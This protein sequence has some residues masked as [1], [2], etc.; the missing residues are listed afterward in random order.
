MQYTIGVTVHALCACTKD[1]R[2][3]AVLTWDV[4]N[5]S[6]CSA[7]CF[8]LCTNLSSQQHVH[9]GND[10]SCMQQEC[11]HIQYFVSRL[12]YL[13]DGGRCIDQVEG[14]AYDCVIKC[15]IASVQA[16][17]SAANAGVQVL[18][19]EHK[20]PVL[21]GG[22]MEGTKLPMLALARF[23]DCAIHC[24][25]HSMLYRHGWRYV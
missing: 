17:A 14:D 18:L 22:C 21:M 9:A 12:G 20:A 4:F 1:L 24:L 19:L 3:L 16:Y 2:V 6:M 7:L 23:M 13:L 25:L 5:F 8:R 11:L 15:V 10:I